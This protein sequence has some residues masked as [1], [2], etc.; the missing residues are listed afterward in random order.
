[1]TIAEC[2]RPFP[3]IQSL[4]ALE[5]TGSFPVRIH[6]I[7]DARSVF[8]ALK[9]A[10]VK[11]P[12]EISLIMFLCQLKEA[13]L[14][15]SLSKLWWCDTHDMIADGLNKGAVSRQAL[16]DLVNNGIWKLNK[17]AIGHT[18]SRYIPITS[19]QTLVGNP[20]DTT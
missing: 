20:L 19:Q 8:D 4:I 18:E 5:E 1:M 13:L 6:L 11:A 7:V 16:L 14:C 9:A 2:V 17:P 12:S 10:E 3:N 15:H